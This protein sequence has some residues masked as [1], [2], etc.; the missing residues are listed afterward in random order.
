MPDEPDP[1]A[2]AVPWWRAMLGD[3]QFWLPLIVLVG[4]LVLLAWVA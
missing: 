4:G 3:V 2:P 1:A